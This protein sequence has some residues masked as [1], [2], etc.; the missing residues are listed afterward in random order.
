MNEPD[1][2][3][4][5]AFDEAE[6]ELCPD[7][8]CTGLIGSD[9]KCKTCGLALAGYQPR[10]VAGEWAARPA[11]A[12]SAADDDGRRAAAVDGLAPDA[13]DGLAV[14]GMSIDGDDD[15]QLCPDGNCIGLIGS[16]GKCK[17]CGR[18]AAS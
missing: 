11:A 9:G 4:R 13:D 10:P 12:D 16:D 8:N 7:G 6:R 14:G 1:F 15:R 3:D 17:V 5:D 18:S 2:K